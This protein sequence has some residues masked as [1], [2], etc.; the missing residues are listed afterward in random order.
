MASLGH[1]E[2]TKAWIENYIPQLSVRYNFSTMPFIT[3]C[4]MGYAGYWAW[5]MPVGTGMVFIWGMLLWQ[6]LQELLSQTCQVSRKCWE[7]PEKHEDFSYKFTLNFQISP[8]LSDHRLTSDTNCT[9]DLSIFIYHLC[10]NTLN[11]RQ[12]GRHCADDIFKCIFLNWKVRIFIQI[13]LGPINNK[14]A[15]VQIMA[16]H[17]TNEAP[18]H[19]L[20]QWCFI[21]YH[22]SLG[23]NEMT[24]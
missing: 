15:W 19:H 22:V 24:S 23:L 16:W 9:T 13:S 20:N 5:A 12:N 17:G 3:A 7:K 2:L 14:S 18:S 21:L 4:P 6:P 8:K 11:P 10:F 1:S